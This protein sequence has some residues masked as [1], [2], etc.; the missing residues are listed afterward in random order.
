MTIECRDVLCAL[1]DGLEGR[2]EVRE[3]LAA[4]QRCRNHES[5]LSIF[6]TL[7]PD[8][9]DEAA[10]E[11]IMQALPRPRWQLLRVT[12]WIPAALGAALAA[13]GLWL[14]GGVPAGRAV[15]SAGD[16]AP[17]LLSWAFSWVLDLAATARSASDAAVAVVATGGVWAVVAV[18]LAGLGSGWLVFALARRSGGGGV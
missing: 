10:V 7:P 6:A 14:L 3:H 2:D 13:A 18:V 5:L 1:E 9:S 12:T 11:A 8:T 16:S 15:T 4:C 17:S